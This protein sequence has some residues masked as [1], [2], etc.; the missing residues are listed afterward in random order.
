MVIPQLHTLLQQRLHLLLAIP[1]PPSTGRISRHR[2]IPL[3]LPDPLLLPRLHLLQQRNR[4]VRRQR[5]RDVPEVDAPHDL[6]RRHIR[7]NPPH[8]LVERLRPEIPQGVHQGAQSQVH[9]AL[10]RADPAE[11]AVGDEVAPRAA[12]VGGE[13]GEVLVDDLGGEEG[14]GG[15]N[16]FV[17]AADCEGLDHAWFVSLGLSVSFIQM[18]GAVPFHALYAQSLCR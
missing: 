12:P 10:F 3:R 16:E 18:A 9:H 14:D 13:V 4:L 2:T 8:G 17:A 1:Q 5:I 6:L 7:N 15:A 11:L